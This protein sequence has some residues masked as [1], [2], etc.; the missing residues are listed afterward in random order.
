M[1]LNNDFYSVFK[2]KRILVTGHTGFKGSWL[3][4]WLQKLG[5]EVLGYALPPLRE[6]DHFNLLHLDQH[7]KHIEANILD[8]KQLKKIIGDFKPEILFHLA[9]QALVRISYDQP[10]E[11]FDVNVG[12]SINVL[13]CVRSCESIRALIY[14]TSDKC[15]RNKEWIWGYRENDELGGHDPYS[16]SKAAAEIVFSAYM[17]AFFQHRNDLGVA[18]VRAGN[19]IGGGDW[20]FDRIVPDCVRALKAKKPVVIRNPHAVRPWQHVLEPLSG[21]LKLAAMLLTDPTGFSGAWNFGP[22]NEHTVT[23]EDLA[24]KI[25]SE[26]GYGEIDYKPDLVFKKETNILRLNCDKANTQLQWFP[27]WNVDDGINYTIDWYKRYLMGQS[28]LDLTNNDI[29]KYLED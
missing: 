5:A 22:Q 3:A 2:G 1:G 20:A 10:K 9:A 23:V 28:V 19:V 25:I 4:F 8:I 6:Y 11:T 29:E 21:Y 12:G 18:S 7:I 27:K 17:N 26:F 16:S 24:K 14:V 13:D 15:Y